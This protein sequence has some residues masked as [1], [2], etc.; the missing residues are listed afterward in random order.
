MNH[1]KSRKLFSA[2]LAAVILTGSTLGRDSEALL[3]AGAEDAAGS[4]AEAADSGMVTDAATRFVLTG[5]SLDSASYAVENGVAVLKDGV[6]SAEAP[7]PQAPALSNLVFDGWRTADN[8]AAEEYSED[9][10]YYAAWQYSDYT[11]SL[12]DGETEDSLVVV[13]KGSIA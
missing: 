10:T 8:T 3:R 7:V 9:Q 2:F 13:K 4:I 1:S 5:G 6:A 11:L 12:E